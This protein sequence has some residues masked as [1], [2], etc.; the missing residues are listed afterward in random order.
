MGITIDNVTMVETVAQIFGMISAF[1]KDNTPRYV[2]T[3]NVNFI[4]NT[5]SWKTDHSRHPELLDILRHANLVTPDGMPVVWASKIMDSPIKERVAGSDMVLNLAEKAAKFGKS[6]FLFGGEP[7]LAEEASEKLKSDYPGL[8]I[9]GTYSPMVATEGEAMLDS[10]EED[11]EIVNKIN[12]SGADILFIGLGNPKQEIWFERNK[13]SLNVPVS[14]GIGGSFSFITG[15]VSRAP[16]W[17]QKNGLEW[18]Y[19]IFQ[20]PGRLWKRYFKDSIKFGLCILFPIVLHKFG[21]LVTKL[22]QPGKSLANNIEVN[23]RSKEKTVIFNMPR[24]VTRESTQNT[25]RLIPSFKESALIIDFKNTVYIDLYGM[26]FL[27]S[28]WKHSIIHKRS[29]FLTSINPFLRWILKYNRLWDIFGKLHHDN[30]ATLIEGIKIHCDEHSFH[31]T[32]D[33]DEN[34]FKIDLYGRLD[35]KNISKLD[36]QEIIKIIDNKDCIINL[37]N[38]NF[39]DNTGLVFF[40][41]LKKHL[42]L[43]NKVP[44]VCNISEDIRQLFNIT[45]LLNFFKILPEYD[46]NKHLLKEMI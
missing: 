15:A 29:L 42:S 24:K 19:R 33:S 35:S 9:A 27:M 23:V 13:T 5:L 8:R 43:H 25:K 17:M 39:I 37:K 1:Q 10:A 46:S 6:I 40:L 20:D 28:I 26:G 30:L 21:S 18:I 16:V 4:V 14:I 45:K 34:L 2:A 11:K 12:Q 31:Y 38:L 32:T 41:K 36:M 7:G 44:I 3:V 22:R